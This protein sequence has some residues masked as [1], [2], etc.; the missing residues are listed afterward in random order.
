[1]ENFIS[2]VVSKNGQTSDSHILNLTDKVIL[3]RSDKY[4]ASSNLSIYFAWKNIIKKSCKTT[5]LK[6]LF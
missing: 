6:Y 3:K 2:C 4:T 1:M 5:N